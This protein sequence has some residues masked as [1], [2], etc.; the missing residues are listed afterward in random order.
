VSGPEGPLGIVGVR[1]WNAEEC[2]DGV[3]NV[4]F[5]DAALSRD[6]RR[7]IGEC[8]IEPSLDALR[9]ECHG[10]RCGAHDVN[11]QGRNDSPLDHRLSREL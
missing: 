6:D 9:T 5:D 7:E 10:E 3:T 2:M 11:E 4:F 8:L 1:Q